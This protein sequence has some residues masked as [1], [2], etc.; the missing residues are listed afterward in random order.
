MIKVNLLFTI[1]QPQKKK[2]KKFTDHKK[3][4]NQINSKNQSL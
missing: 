2:N 3:E 4:T 1:E